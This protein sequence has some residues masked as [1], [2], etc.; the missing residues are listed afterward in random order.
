MTPESRAEPVVLEDVP[1]AAREQVV[2][3]RP[4]LSSRVLAF[5]IPILI[6]LGGLAFAGAM[7]ATRPD[8]ERAEPESQGLPVRVQ[9]L[10]PSSEAIVVHAHGQVIA[11][12]RVVMQPELS[13]RVIWMNEDL[14]PGGRIAAG[15]PLVRIDPRDYRTSME[16]QRAQLESSRLAISQEESRRVIAEREW[17][18]LGHRSGAGATPDGRQLALREPQI[19]SARASLRAAESSVRQARTNLSRTTVTAPFDAFVQTE[20]VEIGQLVGPSTQLAVLVGTERFWVQVAVPMERL[21]WIR[22]P[23][24]GE[25]GASV[26]ITQQLGENDTIERTGRVVRLLGDLDPVGR[27]AR[28]VIEIDDPLGDER[29]P[30]TTAAASLPMLLGAFVRVAIDAGTLESVFRIPREA[31]HAG[32]RVFL[33]GSG[34]LQIVEADVV[35]RENDSVLVRGLDPDGELVLSQLATPIAGTSLRRVEEEDAGGP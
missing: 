9:S 7:V 23:R 27:M 2:V 28:V 34:E 15:A 31:L 11:A 1:E 12:R 6:C 21:R 14:V 18:L 19:R 8:A 4:G 32:D 3:D 5:A 22:L 17:A 30:S 20:N 25:P 24:D 35:W 29:D 13:G 26:I 10:E 33:Y 16:V